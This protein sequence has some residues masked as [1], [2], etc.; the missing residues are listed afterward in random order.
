MGSKIS[1]NFGNQTIFAYFTGQKVHKISIIFTFSPYF[2]AEGLLRGLSHLM[3]QPI[4][5]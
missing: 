2:S 5:S 3:Y 4:V 1:Q